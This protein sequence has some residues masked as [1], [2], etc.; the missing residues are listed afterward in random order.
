[1]RLYLNKS[2][3]RI[4][5]YDDFVIVGNRFNGNFLFIP[6]DIYE[7]IKSMDYSFSKKNLVEK[8]CENDRE[9]V[10]LLIDKMYEYDL[11]QDRKIKKII[12]NYISKIILEITNKCNLQCGYCC[13]DSNL[14]EKDLIT[15][16]RYFDIINKLV[17]LEPKHIVISGG[18]PMLRDDIVDI[19]K[20]LKKNFNGYISLS[21]NLTYN[22]NNLIE[23]SKYIDSID[24][25]LDGYNEETCSK[26]RGKGVFGIVDKN[27]DI[28]KQYNN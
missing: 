26:Y 4:A 18:E 25:T 20:Y 28:L 6:L 14:Q 27:I 21:T 1:M 5:K 10:E 15:K 13:M 3:V 19:V 17:F 23:I 9:Y 11:I 12:N 8:S 22:I 7:M 16:E 24:V 2:I